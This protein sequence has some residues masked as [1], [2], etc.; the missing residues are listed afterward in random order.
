VTLFLAYEP[1]PAQTKHMP[2]GGEIKNLTFRELGIDEDIVTAL[3]T[4]GITSPFPIQEQAIP[5]ALSGKDLIGQAKTGTGKTFGF[6]LPVIQKLGLNPEKKHLALVVVPTRELAQQVAADLVLATSNRSVQVAEILGGKSYEQQI[7]EL[8]DGRQIIVGTPGRLNDLHQKG[9]LKYSEI[10]YLVLDEAD[11]ML[12]LGFLPDIEKIFAATPKEKQTLLFSA[13]MPDVILTLARKHQNKPVHIR[14][15]GEDQ[16]QT[17]ADIKQFVYRAHK[18]DKDELVAK[19]LQSK[20]I[21]KAIIFTPTK[22]QAS[23]LGEVLTE[24]G[25]SATTLHGDMGQPAR[26]RSMKAFRENK[27]RIMVATEVAARGIDV[28]DV[29]HVINY[30]T[31]EDEKAYLHRTGRTGRA[32]KKGIAI[33]LVD[34]DDI[35]RWKMINKALELDFDEPL[36]T[37]SSSPHLFEQ[38][39]IPKDAKGSLSR[40]TEPRGQESKPGSA[41]VAPKQRRR[42]RSYSNSKPAGK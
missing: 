31:P 4:K 19:I 2:L 37:Y 14:A 40:K 28:D 26:E 5:I 34:W 33:T 25:F 30:S 13:T 12:D 7:A 32:G 20:D 39:E 29:S 21:E 42:T 41:P 6:G 23:K 17:K 16:Q 36:E 22:R 10:E 15:T 24:R 11:E 9:H 35:N 27:K 18:L 8:Q 3:E 38:L 1:N